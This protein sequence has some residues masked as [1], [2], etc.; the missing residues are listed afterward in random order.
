[1]NSQAPKSYA[2]LAK[3]LHTKSCELEG[4][5]RNLTTI[6]EEL[7]EKCSKVL[8]ALQQICGSESLAARIT[9][10]ICYSRERT[11]AI[12][13]CGHGGVCEACSARVL[14]RGRCHSCRSTVESVVR[15]FL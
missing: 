9:C 2:G 11:H 13:P 12:L 4:H 1:M 14:R 8:A 15:I 7:K 5:L 3:S 10:S 6:N